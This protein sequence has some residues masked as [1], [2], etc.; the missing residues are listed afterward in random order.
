MKQFF[1]PILEKLP[2]WAFDTLGGIAIWQIIGLILPMLLGLTARHIVRSSA[3]LIKWVYRNNPSPWHD[4]ILTT[5]IKP[6]GL[7]LTSGIWLVSI[8]LLGFDGLMLKWMT[9]LLKLLLTFSIIWIS[10]SLCDL[11]KNHLLEYSRRNEHFMDE[12]IAILIARSLKIFSVVILALLGAQNM[13][14]EV[15]SVLAGLGIGGLALALAAKDTLANLFGS[16]MIMIDRPFRVGHLISVAGKE[17]VVEDIGFRSTRIRTPYHSVISIPNSELAIAAADNLSMRRIRRSIS[18]LSFSHD[19][20]PDL[21]KTFITAI[22]GLLEKNPVVDADKSLVCLHN[23]SPNS[24]DIQLTLFLKTENPKVEAEQRQSLFLEILTLAH[25]LNLTFSSTT[26]N[27]IL[28]N[29]V[30]PPSVS[31]PR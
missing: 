27:L 9:F 1:N 31:G 26:P 11:L 14:I 17:G 16:I 20:R 25:T 22:E 4:R 7:A 12:Q 15:F 28:G 21:L 5:T 6:L 3:G 18:T 23:F 29:E 13:G 8:H 2:S 30:K 24:L 10:S 19:T